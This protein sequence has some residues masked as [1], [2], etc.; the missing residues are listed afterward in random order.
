MFA[1]VYLT[2]H[3]YMYKKRNNPLDDV[4]IASTK[5][6]YLWTV[7]VLI[8]YSQLSISQS[9]SHLKLLVSQVNFLVPDKFT[10]TTSRVSQK[11]R[12]LNQNKRKYV[13]TAL[14]E[15]SG[16]FEISAFEITRVSCIFNFNRLIFRTFITDLPM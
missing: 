7:H 11:S 5:I 10:F 14:F 9:Q 8:E 4:Y 13:K 16:Y 1:R 15:I 3:I 6:L 12:S 2:Q